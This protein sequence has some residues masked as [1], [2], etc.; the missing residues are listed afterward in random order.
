MTPVRRRR[1][2]IVVL[3][4]AATIVLASTEGPAILL[5]W[6]YGGVLLAGFVAFVAQGLFA[7]KPADVPTPVEPV[8]LSE[9]DKAAVREIAVR[10]NRP[11]LA[12]T[13]HRQ[14]TG[15]LDSKIGGV[16]YLPPGF[17]YPHA[18]SGDGRPLRLLCQLNFGTLPRLAGFPSD[19]ILQFYIGG[20]EYGLD[21]DRPTTQDRWRVVFHPGPVG[22]ASPS[23]PPPPLTDDADLPFSAEYV[24]TAT[25]GVMPITPEDF[26]WD[27]FLA[28]LPRQTPV[29]CALGDPGRSRLEYTLAE[30][31]RS[32]GSRIGGYPYFTQSDPRPGTYEAYTVLLLQIDS[33]A[34]IMWGDVGVAGWFITPDAL[35]RR[36]FSTVLYNWDCV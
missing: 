27:E 21:L 13:P 23:V 12:L 7:P 20:D 15:L 28:G 19:G 34:D 32:T 35:A 24:L 5:T 2:F 33:E 18:T 1:V 4:V 36:D 9:E 3:V 10:T 26:G 11:Y 6:T 14:T 8:E 16:P 30:A 31:T 22:Q 17:P 29:S 25:P